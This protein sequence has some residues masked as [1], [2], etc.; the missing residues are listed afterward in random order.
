MVKRPFPQRCDGQ[1]PPQGYVANGVPLGSIITV[2]LKNISPGMKGGYRIFR[3][4]N[5]KG[6]IGGLK[7]GQKVTKIVTLWCRSD[8]NCHC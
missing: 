3:S 1:S 2:I 6:K 5:S 4:C 7:S 8:K